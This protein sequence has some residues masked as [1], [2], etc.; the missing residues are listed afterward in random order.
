MKEGKSSGIAVAVYV[1]EI[2]AGIQPKT[3]YPQQR[4]EEIAACGNPRVRQEKYFAWELLKYAMKHALGLEMEG[5]QFTKQPSGKWTTPS[6]CFSISHSDGM[7]MV[8]V[9]TEEVGVDIEVLDPTKESTLRRVLTVEEKSTIENI[10]KAQQL[11]ALTKLW[12]GKESVFKAW[13]KGVFR[14]ASIQVSDYSIESKVELYAGRLYA[15]SVATERI[16]EIEWNF[17]NEI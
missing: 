12:T 16:S 2:P 4:A 10:P 8:A 7:A 1:A 5:V 11:E 6:C 3:V 14:P 17:V 9:S 13:G 15:L